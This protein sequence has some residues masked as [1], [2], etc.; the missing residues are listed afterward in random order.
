MGQLDPHLHPRKVS[1]PHP[2]GP[3]IELRQLHQGEDSLQSASTFEQ[4]R[5]SLRQRLP[6]IEKILIG[7]L[8]V[9]SIANAILILT[10]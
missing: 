1:A 3:N 9:T 8:V 7:G 2:L 6:P 10:G 5:N 4:G